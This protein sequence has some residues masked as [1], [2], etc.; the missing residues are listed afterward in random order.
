MIATIT[1]TTETSFALPLFQEWM[2]PYEVYAIRRS[3][4]HFNDVMTG[5]RGVQ[6]LYLVELGVITVE[7]QLEPT[8]YY[9]P[10]FGATD[11]TK[12]LFVRVFP[13]EAVIPDNRMVTLRRGVAAVA[14]PT[15]NDFMP[16]AGI[17]LAVLGG[18]ANEVT[19][20]TSGITPP[21]PYVFEPGQPVF[22]G[23]DGGLVQNTDLLPKPCWFQMIGLAVDTERV[24]LAISG[25]MT[26]RA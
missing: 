9:V 8:D 16:A 23:P 25:Q 2:T 26:F 3:F 19:V 12:D 22:V 7:F 1:N 6:F 13:T 15:Q 11:N 10:F 21:L 24:T 5:P 4:A 20:Q 18:N 14:D 17:T